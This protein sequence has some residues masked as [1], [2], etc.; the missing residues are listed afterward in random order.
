MK[1]EVSLTEQEKNWKSLVLY[2]ITY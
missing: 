1:I 2:S